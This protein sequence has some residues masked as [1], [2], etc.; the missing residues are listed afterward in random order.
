MFAG[1]TKHGNAELGLD[2]ARRTRRRRGRRAASARARSRDPAAANI[3]FIAILSIATAE[4]STPAPTYGRPASS[5]S[6]ARFRP[7]RRDRA[8]TGSRRRRRAGARRAR[9]RNEIALH[10]ERGRQRCRGP[11]PACAAR[12]PASNQ[13]PS[14]VIPTGTTSYFAGSSAR[15]TA[16]AVTRETS[17]SADWPPNNSMTRR[18]GA[19]TRAFL[20]RSPGARHGCRGP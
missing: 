7:R 20:L 2:R 17:C 6:P 8:A 11:R 5:S 19:G 14:V 4:P 15:A 3:C 1:F 12:R 18:R 10:G 13:R 9:D 16:T